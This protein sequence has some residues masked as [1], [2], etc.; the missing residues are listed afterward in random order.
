MGLVP[1]HLGLLDFDFTQLSDDFR[2]I[3]SENPV[4]KWCISPLYRH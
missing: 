3:H 4:L 1:Y 2:V